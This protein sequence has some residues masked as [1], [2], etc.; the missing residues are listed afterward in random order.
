MRKRGPALRFYVTPPTGAGMLLTA[1][2]GRGLAPYPAPA[3][4]GR[5]QTA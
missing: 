4:C 3:G 1:D 2:L 5:D